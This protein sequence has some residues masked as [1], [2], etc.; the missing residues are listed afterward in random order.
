MIFSLFLSNLKAGKGKKKK[1]TKVAK[2]QLKGE[3]TVGDWGDK[4]REVFTLPIWAGKSKNTTKV[5]NLD[6]IDDF[7]LMLQKGKKVH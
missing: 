4:K 3:A 5:A 6:V 2:T 1:T 7:K